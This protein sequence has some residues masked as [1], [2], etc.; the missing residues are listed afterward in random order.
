MMTKDVK[1]FFKCFLAFRDSFVENCGGLN[2][3]G[4]GSSIIKRYDLVGV[5]VA[6]LGEMCH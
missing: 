5:G 4:S 1:H 6:L 2:I 3:Y